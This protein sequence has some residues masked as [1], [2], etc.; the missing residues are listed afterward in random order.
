MFEEANVR[1]VAVALQTNERYIE[2]DWHLIRALAVIT[3]IRIDGVTAVFSGGTSL[4]TAWQLIHRFS[5]DIDFKVI[6]GATGK[7]ME[8]ARRAFREAVVENLRAAGFALDG[9][10][11]IASESTFFR[12][13]FHYGPKFPEAAGIRPAL[14]VEIS[15]TGT[16]LAPQN[17]AAQSLLSR[18]LKGAP[19][20]PSLLCVDVVETAADKIS[21][22]AWRTAARDR[23][24]EKDDPAVVRH[25]HDLAAL[26]SSVSGNRTFKDLATKLLD[27]DAGRTRLPGATGQSI[28]EAMLPAIAE[29]PLWRKEYENFVSAVSFGKDAERISFDQAVAACEKLVVEIRTP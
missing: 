16:N 13:R 21:A 22:L 12:A 9:E 8:T 6:L 26:A 18:L 24:S 25:L 20:V 2:K 11:L 10:P 5:E 27:E 28:V 7:K 4:A 3:S 17:R 15:F 29:D 1:R 14:Q 23:T 19:E